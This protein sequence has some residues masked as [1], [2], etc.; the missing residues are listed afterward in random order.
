MVP[1]VER[2]DLWLAAL[3]D[4]PGK[5][6]D[7]FVADLRDIP[8]LFL[9]L[10]DAPGIA[11]RL[12]RDRLLGATDPQDIKAWLAQAEAGGHAKRITRHMMSKAQPEEQWSVTKAG[13]DYLAGRRIN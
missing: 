5:T 10:F 11:S 7:E 2:E 13:Q 9:D 3:R 8:A 6:D 4:N 1:R 12:L